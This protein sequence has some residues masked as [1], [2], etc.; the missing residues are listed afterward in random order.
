MGLIVTALL[1]VQ[2]CLHV[3]IHVCCCDHCA[4]SFPVIPVPFVLVN[5]DLSS[6]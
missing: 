6:A 3:I 2:T 5:F 1:L 4:A